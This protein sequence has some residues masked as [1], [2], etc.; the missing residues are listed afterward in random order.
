MLIERLFQ[1]LFWSALLTAFVM[2]ILPQP[3]ALPGNPNDKIL[4]M[5]AFLVLAGLAAIAYPRLRLVTVFLGLAVFGG[6]I[7]VVQSLPVLGRGPSL[8]DWFADIAAAA[9]VLVAV[10]L[11]RSWRRRTRTVPR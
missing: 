6:A 4:H 3:P 1:L 2:A 9:V 11:M 5:L 10:G 7:E 8:L